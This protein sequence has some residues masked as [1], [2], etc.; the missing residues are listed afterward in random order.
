[1]PY[2]PDRDL[3]EAVTLAAE[4]TDSQSAPGTAWAFLTSDLGVEADHVPGL[5]TFIGRFQQTTPKA[6]N[7]PYGPLMAYWP[8]LRMMC[9]GHRLAQ[10]AA[11]AV[12][13]SGDVALSGWA[14]A[15][16]A[17]DLTRPNVPPI[18]LAPQLAA[19]VEQ[20]NFYGNNAYSAGFGRDR[21]KDI[22]VD[23]RGHALLDRALI[24]SALLARG[25]SLAALEALGKLIGSVEGSR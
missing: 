15:A 22:L 1:M 3:R 13:E 14:S 4:W 24:L 19:A 16:H 17:V 7:P 8:D 21:A 18:G 9:T 6:G 10:G 23:L 2:A 25:A 20:L 12:V 11:M 5:A